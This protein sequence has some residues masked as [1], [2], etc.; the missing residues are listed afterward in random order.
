MAT[1]GGDGPK[2]PSDEGPKDGRRPP[3]PSCLVP[4]QLVARRYRIVRLLGRGGMGE[5]YEAQDEL[6]HEAVALKTLRL[7]LVA[8]AGVAARFESEMRLA[9]KVAHPSVCRV[10]EVGAHEVHGEPPLR[11]ITM[12][13]LRGESLSA[14]IRRVRRLTKEQAFPLAAQ[15]AAG[16][17]A[18]HEHGIVHADFKSS[19]V[20]IVPGPDGDRAKITDFGLAQIDPGFHPAEETR[21]MHDSGK[22]V[23]TVAYMS[24]EQMEGS[25]I[26]TS[27]DIY[28]LGIVLFEMATGQRPFDGSH[29]IHAAMQRVSGESIAPR[30][31][32]P[33]I[34]RRW[35][36]AIVRCLQRDRKRRFG[37]AKQVADW[38]G[39]GDGRPFSRWTRREW[40]FAGGAAAACV[41]GVGGYWVWSHVPYSPR[42]ASV[43]WYRKGVNELHATTYESARRSL[44]QAVAID[45]QFALAY[46][47]LAQAYQELDYTE[48]AKESMLKAMTIAQ[49]TRLSAADERRLNAYQF[50]VAR[51]YDRAAPL[52]QEMERAASS[53]EKPAAA[54][55]SG[56][57]AELAGR[58]DEA[59]RDYERALDA[60]PTYAPAKLRLGQMLQLRRELPAALRNFQDAE[61]LFQASSDYEGVTE[62]LR[63]QAN[64]LNRSGRA[65][66]ALPLIDRALSD[67]RTVGSLYLEIRLEL[68]QGVAYRSLGDH[69][70]A[71]QIASKAID[72]ADAEHMDNLASIALVDLGNSYILRGDMKSAEPAYRRALDVARR[73]KVRKTEARALVSLASFCEQAGRPAEA[74]GYI[75]QALPFYKEAGYRL[76][77]V[78]ATT[79]LGG[80]YS[81]QAE[82]KK[83]IQVLSDVL[84]EAVKL[85]DPG[86]EEPVRERLAEALREQ[87]DWPRAFDETEKALALLQDNESADVRLTGAR[88]LWGLGRRADSA[89][90]VAETERVLRQ[91]PDPSDSFELRLLKAEIAYDEGRFAQADSLAGE[92]SATGPAGVRA[93]GVRAEL[94]RGVAAIRLHREDEGLKIAAAAVD[95]IDKASLL[96]EAAHARLLVGEALVVAGRAGS[97]GVYAARA[98][99]FFEPRGIMEACWRA[100][101]VAAPGSGPE[102]SG[103][104]RAAARSALAELKASWPAQDVASYMAR[105]EIGKAARS[106]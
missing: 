91:N 10:F 13:L 93:A 27:S 39:D 83:G 19:N 77:V 79:I 38:F 92:G 65:K 37:S 73:G 82:Y 53:A 34:D 103:R 62:A 106:L 45:P 47:S 33:N 97:A 11:F 66:E 94:L 32:V 101:L 95:E 35:E 5:V 64:L 30:K 78:K 104:H 100:H 15:M 1:D 49:E 86:A 12:E 69:T 105:P 70:R 48:L 74:I 67:A 44:E 31:L 54:L 25:E 61:R 57:L 81:Q 9:R 75:Q 18:A 59:V 22:L 20:I 24:P 28:S 88:L 51:E 85:G 4:G 16:L 29:V 36:M 7:D 46:A 21:T 3:A 50:M 23:G 71:E 72:K 76:E 90:W 6:I 87:G 102:E 41:G 40:L 63:L 58:T 84:P 60:N 55:E 43:E 2:G 42:P 56:W 96:S 8:D 98:L 14:R 99:E 26:T 89:Q 68:L 17:Q 80:V 52:L